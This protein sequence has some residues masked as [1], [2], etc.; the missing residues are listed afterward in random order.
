MT[1]QLSLLKYT[2]E[3]KTGA[4]HLGT[5]FALYE[6]LIPFFNLSIPNKNK[7]VL[8]EMGLIEICF[9]VLKLTDN[10]P[11]VFVYFNLDLSKQ[12]AA[13]VCILILLECSM[14]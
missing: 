13:K 4:I 3:H 1:T 7:V 14:H 8:G 2:V 10:E 9:E 11:S 5:T 6:L 12:G